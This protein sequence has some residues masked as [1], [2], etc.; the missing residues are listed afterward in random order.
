M[1][2]D[3]I[4]ALDRIDMV[5]G[6]NDPEGEG[7]ISLAPH[8]WEL[9]FQA[10]DTVRKS[11]TAKEPNDGLAERARK[12]AAMLR[13]IAQSEARGLDWQANLNATADFLAALSRPDPATLEMAAKVA[14]EKGP[15]HKYIA[16]A[17]R[18]L[19]TDEPQDDG[20]VAELKDLADKAFREAPAPW[21]TDTEQSEGE[22]GSGPN[23]FSG[24][25]VSL[26]IDANGRSLFDA[27]NS[28]AIIV[29][30][31]GPDEDG[32]VHAWDDVSAANAALIVALVNNLP[33]ILAALRGGSDE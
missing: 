30:E 1:T 18:A 6:R 17:I 15:T 14:E 27:L 13:E 3:A 31:D 5:L 19:K 25:D 8:G 22:Y 16:Q 10:L 20:L 21:E 28:T 26:L 32:Y 7:L 4:K 24:F 2:T 9:V 29:H 33:R 11:L 12:E 23:T